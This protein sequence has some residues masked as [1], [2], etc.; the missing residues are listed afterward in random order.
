MEVF[1]ECRK[2]CA[3]NI[4]ALFVF[5]AKSSETINVLHLL[6]TLS[7]LASDPYYLVRRNIGSCLHEVTIKVILEFNFEQFIQY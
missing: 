2:W 1:M 3:Y 4:P 7:N 5:V 6:P